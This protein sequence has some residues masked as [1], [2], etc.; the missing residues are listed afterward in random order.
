[1]TVLRICKIHKFNFSEKIEYKKIVVI[2][3]D[4]HLIELILLNEMYPVE[5][6]PN[7][8]TQEMREIIMFY[9]QTGPVP[10]IHF[11]Y[12]PGILE[13]IN[14]LKRYNAC[15][16]PDKIDM[17]YRVNNQVVQ[18]IL[19]Q[20]PGNTL[21]TTAALMANSV[22]IASGFHG[23]MAQHHRQYPIELLEKFSMSKKISTRLLIAVRCWTEALR[24]YPPP[25]SCWRDLEYADAF[26]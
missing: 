21:N 25:S 12:T 14:A 3:M 1:M 23:F 18:T 20:T 4:D 11:T 7:P 19:T 6:C 9:L 8:F 22:G 13:I 15:D 24:K 26:M 16:M 2:A 10:T 5:F 17:Y